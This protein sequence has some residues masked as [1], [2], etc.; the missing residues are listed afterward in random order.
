MVKIVVAILSLFLVNITTVSS[1]GISYFQSGDIY[2]A[3]NFANSQKK[4][5]IVEFHAPWNYRSTWMN[6]MM[7]Q[8]P[9]V[10]AKLNE[11]FVVFQFDT[12]TPQGAKFAA[13]YSVTDYPNILIF[14]RSGDV[15]DKI[16]KNM[17]P[18]DFMEHLDQVQFNTDGGAVWRLQQIISAAENN[19]VNEVDALFASLKAKYNDKII[20][21]P[22]W[23]LFSNDK[24]TYY[25]SPALDFLLANLGEYRKNLG[26]ELVDK[27]LN[28]VF[29][30][31]IL[32]YLF[33]N[34]N[35]DSMIIDDL[36]NLVDNCQLQSEVFDYAAIMIKSRAK[37]DISTYLITYPK[38]SAKLPE[39]M[40]FSL[41]LTLELVADNGTADQ[42]KAAKRL[43][44]QQ[45]QASSIPTQLELLQT[46][47]SRF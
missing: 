5:L 30:Q 2:S 32:S 21:K 14:N 41:V 45:M 20:T 35:A 9:Q 22:F 29:Q 47:V 17:D 24:I 46:L 39:D 19:K 8:T 11:E 42:K 16:E 28:A 10:F 26:V 18:I 13:T 33:T 12:Q 34:N 40:G 23:T 37:N 3:L 44:E 15:I 25:Y 6:N 38:L 4:L 7:N 31:T 43:V 36:N 1:Q 27:R